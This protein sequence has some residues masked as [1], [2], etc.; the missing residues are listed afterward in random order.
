MRKLTRYEFQNMCCEYG[1]F[2]SG[3][4]RQ[5]EKVT[6][7]ASMLDRVDAEYYRTPFEAVVYMTYICS[8]MEIFT[9]NDIRDALRE[10]I[11]SL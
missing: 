1:W 9:V 8:D 7:Y 11:M 2:T 3:C 5:Y 4:V 10:K 6:E